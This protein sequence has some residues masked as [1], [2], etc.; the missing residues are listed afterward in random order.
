MFLYLYQ[1]SENYSGWTKSVLQPVFCVAYELNGLYTFKGLGVGWKEEE[2][3]A[4]ETV[5]VPQHL[6]YLLSSPLQKVGQP[7][8]QGSTL[9]IECTLIAWQNDESYVK[10]KVS[11]SVW[12]GLWKTDVVV[13]SQKSEA[14]LSDWKMM[15]ASSS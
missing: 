3:H 11:R 4:A 9:Q 8:A 12:K 1:R 13:S 7:V 15:M 5:C 6:T 2:E 14:F 10:G